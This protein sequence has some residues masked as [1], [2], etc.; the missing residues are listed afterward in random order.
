M[1][2]GTDIRVLVVST[3]PAVVRELC[4]ALS[5][6]A[7]GAFSFEVCESAR[8]AISALR[9]LPSEVTLVDIG[10]GDETGL[11]ELQ[12]L[13]S[14]TVDSALIAVTTSADE[15]VAALAFRHGAQDC[16][17][18]G[19]DDTAPSRLARAIRHALARCAYDGSRP[20]ATMIE[21]SSDAILTMNRERVITRFNGAA[22]KLYGWRAHEALGKPAR[23]LIPEGGHSAQAAF[24]DRV[25]NGE[26]IDAFQAPRT[27]RDGRKVIMSMSGSP[28]VDAM[29]DVVEACLIIRDVTEEVTAGLRLAEQQHLLESSQAAG[30]LGSWAVDRMTGRMEWSTEH[31][32]L[33]KRDPTLGPATVEELIAMVHPDDQELVRASLNQQ[34]GFSFEARLIVDPEDVRILQVRGEYVPRDDG[35][36]GK[37]LGITQD[38]TKERA[39][40]AARQRVEEQLQ[41]SFEEA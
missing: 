8:D 23:M 37:L 11:Q 12:L 15:A 41:R 13:A 10:D 5:S 7:A 25:F 30:R 3:A 14:T 4:D 38:V 16:L 26:S 9:R 40:L 19:S 18:R 27:M 1:S 33:L 36:P 28:I 29:G 34:E 2:G 20:L 17:I 32:R 24:V 22:E 21:L 39:A 31:Y 6:G 35:S